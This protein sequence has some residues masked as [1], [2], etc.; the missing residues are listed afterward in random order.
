MKTLFAVAIAAA[1]LAAAPA[2]A[3]TAPTQTAQ[4]GWYVG[5]EAGYGQVNQGAYDNKGSYIGGIKGGYRFAINP[6]ASVG[7]EAGYQYLGFVDAKGA[8]N[9]DSSARGRF[10]APTLGAN[11]RWNFTPDWYAEV[12]AGA[13]YAKGSGLTN[14]QYAYERIGNIRPYAGVG[15]GYNINQH[16]SVGVNYNYYDATGKGSNQGVQLQTNAV[17]VAGEYRF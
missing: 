2:F 1:G 4:Q 16:F 17:T 14:D 10:H 6:E 8:Y 9:G 12:R 7:V 13:F 11:L 15:V 5:A 3:Q